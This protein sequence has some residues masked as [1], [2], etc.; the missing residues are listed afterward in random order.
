MLRKKPFW[1]NGICLGLLLQQQSF[2]T[3][4]HRKVIASHSLGKTLTTYI[5]Q[6]FVKSSLLIHFSCL[7]AWVK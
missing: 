1:K 2:T 6:V 5:E 4:K 3:E 7:A